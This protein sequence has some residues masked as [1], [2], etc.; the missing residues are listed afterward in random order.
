MI[1][2][3]ARIEYLF[4]DRHL[5]LHCWQPEALFPADCVLVFPKVGVTGPHLMALSLSSLQERSEADFAPLRPLL[6]GF[7]L[8]RRPDPTV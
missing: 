1:D 5:T 6:A 3:N 7:G 4:S 8:R 2:Q